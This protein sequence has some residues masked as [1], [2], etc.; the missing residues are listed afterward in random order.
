MIIYRENPKESIKSVELISELSKIA[1]YKVSL[2]KQLH[3]L[4][5]ENEI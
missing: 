5:L 1:V 3:A 2:Q 4:H